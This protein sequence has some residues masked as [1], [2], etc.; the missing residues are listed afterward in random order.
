[1]YGEQRF[2]VNSREL[3]AE[4]QARQTLA[5]EALKE[6]ARYERKLRRDQVKAV[7]AVLSAFYQFVVV[8]VLMTVIVSLIA[9]ETPSEESMDICPELIE[10]Y[11]GD[12]LDGKTKAVI[13]RFSDGTKF[14]AVKEG[15]YYEAPKNK[16]ELEDQM[17]ANPNLYRW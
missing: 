8:F 6:Q 10:I 12:T 1:M 9:C 4:E 16:C 15:E 11:L 14:V 3:T 17:N 5:I 7:G 13:F 2:E